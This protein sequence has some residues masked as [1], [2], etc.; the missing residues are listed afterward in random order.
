MKQRYTN[1]RPLCTPLLII[2]NFNAKYMYVIMINLDLIFTLIIYIP[3][4]D[5]IDNN[6]CMVRQPAAKVNCIQS[7]D[8]VVHPHLRAK[9]FAC[10]SSMTSY[11]VFNDSCPIN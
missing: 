8:V 11:R 7:Q 2:H 4:L 3:F 10:Q 6:S 9:H 5:Q 1:P